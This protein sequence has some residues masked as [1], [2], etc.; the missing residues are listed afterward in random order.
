MEA[1]L[2]RRENTNGLLKRYTYCYL[3]ADAIYRRNAIAVTAAETH[4]L[5]FTPMKNESE[6]FKQCFRF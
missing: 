2:V 3:G 5:P 6:R 4:I 1:Y